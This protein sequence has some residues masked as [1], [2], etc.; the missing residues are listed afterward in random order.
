PV[1]VTGIGKIRAAAGL[2]ACLAAYESAGGPPSVVVNIGTAGALHAHMEGV[3]RVDTVLLHD[4]SHAAIRE[5]TG[6]DEYP[7]LHVGP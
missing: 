7:P 3:H 2:A 4:F 1:L 5:I 6:T